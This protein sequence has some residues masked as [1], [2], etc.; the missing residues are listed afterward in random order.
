M[1]TKSD[2]ERRQMSDGLINAVVAQDQDP[3][4]VMLDM[5]Q[6]CLETYPE[7]SQ[8]FEV[9][10]GPFGVARWLG[11]VEEVRGGDSELIDFDAIDDAGDI[12]PDEELTRWLL[13]TSPENNI[14]NAENMFVD[15]LPVFPAPQ[16]SP[17]RVNESLNGIDLNTSISLGSH[18]M[19]FSIN[20]DPKAWLLL[21]YYRDRII[22]L[23][24][25][26]QQQQPQNDE[27]NDPWSSLV[28]PC[29]MTTMAE[30]TIGG[31]ASHA[32]LALLSA[33]LATSAFHLQ[34]LSTD[35]TAEWMVAGEE[36]TA[37]ARGYLETCLEMGKDKFKYKEVL[38]AILCL[39]NAFV[40][41][42]F[43]VFICEILTR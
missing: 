18:R 34:N 42:L 26:R 43:L 39:A 31:S 29:A 38:M 2:A 40:G 8:S 32:R 5:E 35:L 16:T 33:L 7:G 10:R 14:G 15:L 28:M 17:P 19:A 11:S 36:Y 25:L 13:G 1:L 37:R 20:E 41:F 22:R 30:L 27:V 9:F 24:S 4:Q 6:D 21:S 12:K 3:G 23:I